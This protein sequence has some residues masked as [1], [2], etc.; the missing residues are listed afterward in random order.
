MI[1]HGAI[2]WNWIS[3]NIR[4]YRAVV[5]DGTYGIH[6]NPYRF[7]NIALFKKIP[8]VLQLQSLGGCYYKTFMPCTAQDSFSPATGVFHCNI[9]F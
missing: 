1:E 8:K 9:S 2:I 4:C 5:D 3:K 6:P 7:S